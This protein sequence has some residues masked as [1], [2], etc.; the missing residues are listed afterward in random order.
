MQRVFMSRLYCIYYSFHS[1]QVVWHY[2]QCLQKFYH[3]MVVIIGW[4][5]HRCALTTLRFS[6]LFY[7]MDNM[8][9]NDEKYWQS[10]KTQLG[11]MFC[12]PQY[13]W[14]VEKL[15]WRCVNLKCTCNQDEGENTEKFIKRQACKGVNI[16]ACLGITKNHSKRW[17]NMKILWRFFFF[18]LEIAPSMMQGRF[19]IYRLWN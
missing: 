7:L 4:L 16:I 15:F 17:G 18:E 3:R 2:W 12:V 9:K 6:C 5:V 10:R 8:G 14:H 1:L 19:E 11:W 13:Y